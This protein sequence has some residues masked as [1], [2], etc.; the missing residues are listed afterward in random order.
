MPPLGSNLDTVK[1]AESTDLSSLLNV[2]EWL[3]DTGFLGKTRV[4]VDLVR[5]LRSEVRNTW[6][7]A[8]Q[9]ELTDDEKNE[10]F[11]IAIDFL[12]D[13]EKVSNTENTAC[14]EYLKHLKINKVTNVAECELQSLLLQRQLLDDI[15]EEI[16][17][18]KDEQ[19][20][21]KSAIKENQQK[22]MKL[23][24]AL[25]ECSQRMADFKIFKEN[26][27]KHFRSL[28]EK[29]QSFQSIPEDIHKLRERIEHICS[30]L[31]KTK[32]R[33]IEEREPTSCLPHKVPLF[34]ARQKEIQKVITLL[35]EE[36]AVV[37]LHGGPGI[38][39][40]AIAIEVSQKLRDDHNI[41]VVFSQLTTSTN[42][43]EMVLEMCRD[44]GINHENDPKSSLMLWLRNRKSKVIFVMD[45]IDNLLENNETSF[46]A[47]VHLMRKNSNGNCQIV[48][49]CR[50]SCK[51]PDLL[52]DEVEV[53]EMDDEACMELLRKKCPG[54]DDDFLQTLAEL[55][56][57]IPLAMCIAGSRVD[58]FK[59]S[60]AFLKHLEKQ[61]MKFLKSPKSDQ[62]V[63]RAINM[64]YE[65]CTDKEKDSFA[66]LTVFDGSFSEEAARAVIGKKDLDTKDI[67]EKLVCHSL[68]KQPTKQ[69]YSIHLLIKHFLKEQESGEDETAQRAR[70][71]MMRAQRLMVEY[72]LN[73]GHELT[74]KS[75][76]KDG[77]KD[78]R[79][80]L[81]QEVQN[82][83]KVLKICCQLEDPTIT[84]CLTKSQ[85]YTT[86]A[87]FFAIFVRTIIP[88]SIVDKF[89]EQCAYLAN[90]RKEHGIKINFD[91]L[92]AEQERSKTIG[93]SDEQCY[94]TKME[95]IKREFETYGKGLW[96]E[97]SLCAYYYY[98]CGQ[99]LGRKAKRVKD[100]E[101]LDLY[102]EAHKQFENSL[103]L[104]K[105]LSVEVADT[106][107]SLLKLRNICKIISATKYFLG[108]GNETK[109]WT[110]Q[111]QKHY[112][113]ATKLSQDHL[114]K[115]DLTSACFKYH[116]DFFFK[117]KELNK[118]EEYYSTAKEMRENLG[119]DASEKHALL[120]N[121]LGHCL[122]KTNRAEEAIK[123][124]E[125]ACDLAEKLAESDEPSMCK[126]KIYTSLAIAYDSIQT[127]TEEA[128]KYAKKA[129]EFKELKNVTRKSTFDELEEI[130][131][132]TADEWMFSQFWHIIF[133]NFLFFT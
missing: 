107:F 27:N 56:G 24:N 46:Y 37:S 30:H 99:Y 76:S 1:D 34:T 83:Q 36:K 129:Q 133:N 113:E 95:E 82:V 18:I 128:V 23:Q 54:Q 48:A 40:T 15:K 80:A 12:E 90:E 117:I 120:L 122:T 85:I 103:K 25:S 64:S 106:I 70:E 81:K 20:V 131:P 124:L 116:G 110:K 13:L 50:G 78:N 132:K 86:S 77:Y 45:D 67:L 66:R 35:E 65:K 60:D 32:Q 43:D 109:S 16:T 92:I 87:R 41:P 89:L 100:K 44:I 88:G 127:C 73:L 93:K 8:S 39:K 75:Y 52:T 55:C 6:A 111:A 72:Y 22:L 59:D 2:L 28:D 31:E 62:Y 10:A 58:R 105:T 3:K 112:T 115:H 104:R 74:M 38:G 84:D 125:N 79:K 11:S 123:I 118:A 14:L 9:Q 33:P 102:I 19:S 63:Y 57:K 69:R 68:I 26:I 97:N 29:L 49:T 126:A 17:A 98:Q 21:D 114:G 4:N 51:I 108:E 91:C 61:P 119:L 94:I 53:D 7:H 96:T 121:N 42:V 71:E 47:F 5:E 101:R 130:S